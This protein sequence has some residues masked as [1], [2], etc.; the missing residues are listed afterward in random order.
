MH[1]DARNNPLWN[2]NLHVQF[3]LYQRPFEQNAIVF[4]SQLFIDRFAILH[5]YY[6]KITRPFLGHENEEMFD[7]KNDFNFGFKNFERRV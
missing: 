2:S 3:F 1:T 6:Y 7:T 5:Y 4:D